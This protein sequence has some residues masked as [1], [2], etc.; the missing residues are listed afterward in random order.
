MK[1]VCCQIAKK[2]GEGDTEKESSGVHGKM[3][4]GVCERIC[5]V[6]FDLKVLGGE[7]KKLLKSD[8]SLLHK[9]FSKEN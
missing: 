4:S 2:H 9:F 6:N 7:F 5:N 1:K 8:V 3:E